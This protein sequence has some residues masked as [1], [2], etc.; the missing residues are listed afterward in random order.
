MAKIHRIDQTQDFFGITGDVFKLIGVSWRALKLNLL[1]F[2]LIGLIPI[3]IALVAFA[4]S[5]M[6]AFNNDD[7]S[8][9]N[10]VTLAIFGLIFLI[11]LVLLWPALIITQIKGAEVKRIDFKQVFKRSASI[12]LPFLGLTI[13]VGLIIIVGFIL[14]V[15]PGLLAIFFLTMAPYIYIDKRSGIKTAIKQSYYMVKQNWRLVLAMYIVSIIVSLFGSIPN[16][17][18]AINLVLSVAYFCLTAVIYVQIR[19]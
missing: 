16:I 19:K 15:I 12:A 4:V 8:L 2:I 14:L 9:I 10:I 7:F 5:G 11:A 13:L 17:G 3:V 18:W 1:T 6:P